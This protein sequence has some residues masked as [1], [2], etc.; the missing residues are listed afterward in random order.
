MRRTH[1][2]TF[3]LASFIF[4]N[5]SIA[6]DPS[7]TDGLY[8][9]AGLGVNSPR[10]SSASGTS[11]GTVEF[12]T[13]A[14]G[15]VFVGSKISDNL[16]LEAELSHRSTGIDTIA[17][18][19]ASGDAKAT[20]FMANAV[21]DFDLDL[22]ITPYVG[23]GVGMARISLDNAS[24]FGG[25]SIDG[26]DTITAYQGI[27]GASYALS[28]QMSIFADYRYFAT[29]DADF[30]TA[31]GTATSMDYSSHSA[32]AG[33]RINFNAPQQSGML[34]DG[35]GN[36]STNTSGAHAEPTTPVPEIAEAPKPPAH[37]PAHT[38]AETYVVNFAF[39]K[40]DI[41]EDGIAI[42]EK[43]VHAVKA[44]KVT[45][46]VLTGH[47]DTTGPAPYN[48]DLSIRRA[49]AVKTSLL[50]FGFHK[51]SIRVIG[52]GETDLLVP[53]ADNVYEPKNRR[54]E[55]VLP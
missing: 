39:N 5:P 19:S 28:P 27:A 10:D 46:L 32:L 3:T 48:M 45:R 41:T 4:A 30:T 40:A 7:W 37:T 9:G 14:A 35:D 47:A 13:G 31:S 54:V 20:A 42:I 44:A 16:R 21:L 50:A 17:N 38:M 51:N 55:I 23:A 6:A 34:D 8:G 49:E 29:G 33:L 43:I 53:T 24:P 25:S 22:P 18:T 12:G 36:A 11:G 26:T 2:A 15:V 1:F 52:K